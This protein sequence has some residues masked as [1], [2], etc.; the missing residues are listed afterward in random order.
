[1][2]ACVWKNKEITK[3]PKYMNTDKIISNYSFF[4]QTLFSTQS[5]P[6]A[7]QVLNTHCSL[8]SKR[9]CILRLESKE[10]H[11]PWLNYQ[12]FLG[13]FAH[14]SRRLQVGRWLLDE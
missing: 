2:N 4:P 13:S 11:C 1:M 7:L 14:K 3:N 12:P 8:T 9:M 5:L 6:L 10:D